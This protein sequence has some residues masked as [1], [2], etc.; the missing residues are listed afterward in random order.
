MQSPFVE[1]DR[2]RPGPA[3][4][5]PSLLVELP[6]RHRVFRENLRELL[7]RRRSSP[8]GS[9][10]PAPFW[11][12]VFVQQGAPW[13]ALRQSALYHAFAVVAVWG[14]SVTWAARP[15]YRV[16]SPLA[17]S[18]VVYY[19]PDEYLPP[20]DTGSAKADEQPAPKR[21]REQKGDPA[22]ARQRIVSLPPN[23]DNFRQ[24]IVTASEVRLPHDVP[25]PN[26][27]AVAA[28]TAPVPVAATERAAS[29]L[30]APHIPHALVAPPPETARTELAKT[31]VL[32]V[33]VVAPA[34]E[35][36]RNSMAVAPNL[37]VS[38]IAPPPE[39][40]RAALP[41]TPAVPMP[42]VVEPPPAIS[43]ARSH[44]RA[45]VPVSAVIEPP[46]RMNDV[47]RVGEMNVAHLDT[48]VAAPRLPVPE[49]QALPPGEGAAE[50]SARPPASS[51][52]AAGGG[53]PPSAAI[54]AGT[55]GR[56]GQII[57][58][59]ANPA[60]V[61]GPVEVPGGSRHGEFAAGPEGKP[62][63]SG[64]PEIKGG[65]ASAGS[66]AAPAGAGNTS[67]TLAPPGIS[68][69]PGPKRAASARGTLLASVVPPRVSDLARAMRPGSFPN[70]PDRIEGQVFGTR[71]FYSVALNMPN[72]TSAGGSWI[73]R[74]AELNEQSPAGE[75]TA[76]VATLKVDPAYPPEAIRDQVQGTVTLYAIIHKD[77]SVGEVRVL[78]G[79]D[80]RLD[81][82]A[83]IALARWKFRPATRDG[84]AVDL[85]AVVQIPFRVRGAQ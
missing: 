18:R 54:A 63:A 51:G 72:L 50:A 17:N 30:I 3:L 77:G 41:K 74:F 19:S 1:P 66:G 83:R 78:R 2:A 25:L 16:E 11:P 45:K 34:P 27:V 42:A 75:L 61:R 6:P 33:S 35:I 37:P 21:S 84:V 15:Q 69:A 82:N 40:R 73:I 76:P 7:R 56:G 57:A 4:D 81:E 32:P 20:L 39:A 44:L 38:V 53:V 47:R 79:V 24:T 49:Q 52:A 60:D 13:R 62:G 8:A 23:P 64:A 36:T 55:A 43:N 59:N 85:E 14:L 26:L 58:L 65:A 46:P 71:R 68:V 9:T 5:P 12:D 48:Q 29:Q 31:P 80:T 67:N 70:A 28:A 10:P 22:F